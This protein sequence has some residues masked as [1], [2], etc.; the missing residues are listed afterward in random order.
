M[1]DYLARARVLLEQNRFDLA[2]AE[3]RRQIAIEPDNSEAIIL[4]SQ[5]QSLRGDPSG[6]ETA[7]RALELAPDD[8]SAHFACSRA[9]YLRGDLKGA[10][11]SIRRAIELESWQPV[12]FGHLAAIHISQYD[13]QAAL[14]AADQGLELDPDDSAC[15]NAR[16]AALTKL[17]RHTEAAQTLESGLEANPDDAYSHANRGWTLLHENQPQRAQDHFREALRLEPNLAWAKE[18]LL[19]SI[20]SRNWFYRRILQFFLWLSRFS[21]RVQIGLVLGLYV[22]VQVC[23]GIGN[24][25]PSLSQLC[26]VLVLLYCGFV[27]ATWF[28]KP[29][30]NLIIWTSRDG[31]ILLNTNEKLLGGAIGAIVV[32]VMLLAGVAVHTDYELLIAIAIFI[33]LIGVHLCSVANIIASRWRW[34]G[35]SASLVVLT[36]GAYVIYEEWKLE[37]SVQAL[38]NQLD[39]C[40]RLEYRKPFALAQSQIENQ[41]DPLFIEYQREHAKLARMTDSIRRTRSSYQIH[42]LIYIYGSLATLLLHGYLTIRARRAAWVRLVS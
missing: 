28:A 6:L 8:A 32:C 4:L 40:N 31:R 36:N 14:A 35:I 30:M 20:R 18:G 16:A 21:P 25:N 3:C 33:F 29:L 24:A 10:D 17:G 41:N 42:K 22:F 23:N 13:W 27:A 5:C 12:F 38:K 2:E 37:D 7:H 1:T 15:L 9:Q 19:E 39:I 11:A 34:Y 26:N